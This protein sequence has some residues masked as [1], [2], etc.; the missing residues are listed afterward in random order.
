MRTL[1]TSLPMSAL[2]FATA[3]LLTALP[4]CAAS[5]P[6]S[7]EGAESPTAPATVSKTTGSSKVPGVTGV[8]T[9]KGTTSTST[10]TT[11]SMPTASKTSAGSTTSGWD[12]S[13]PKGSVPVTGG[14]LLVASDGA[15][16]IA[17]DPDR[18]LVSI[19]DLPTHSVVGQIQLPTGA[20]PGRVV[21]DGVG[22]IHVILRRGGGIADIDPVA[23]SLI[24]VRQVCALPRGIAYRASDDSLLVSCMSGALVTMTADPS[25]RAPLANVSV[26]TATAAITDL[27]DVLVTSGGVYLT[28]FRSA[29]VLQV[30]ADGSVLGPVVPMNTRVD[31]SAA[32]LA[33]NGLPGGT[34]QNFVPAVA[35]RAVAGPAGDI[36]VV[37][38]G[39]T[40][41]VINVSIADNGGTQVPVST[42]C[43]SSEYGGETCE[44]ISGAPICT[45]AILIGEI[46]S[47]S[48]TGVVSDGPALPNGALPVDIV[49]SIDGKSYIVALAGNPGGALSTEGKPLLNILKVPAVS[50]VSPAANAAT[51]DSD[52]CGL[53]F[54]SDGVSVP[55]QVTAV[56]VDVMGQTVAQT[57]EPASIQYVT[58]SGVISIPLSSVSVANAGFDLFHTNTGRGMTCAGCH[59][60][61]QDDGRTWQF[62]DGFNADGTPVAVLPR[63]TQTFRAGFLATAPFHWDGEFTDIPALMTDVFV[64]R[65]GASTAPTATQQTALETW[66]DG[67]PAKMHDTPSA[68]LAASIAIGA[69][70][71]QDPTVGCT[72]CHSGANF[73]NNTSTDIGF[74]YPLQVPTLIDVSFRGPFLHDGSAPTLEARFADPTAMSGK[75]GTTSQLSAA[76]IAN[77]VDYLGSL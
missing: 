23:H 57:R 17:A 63:R 53:A 25:T 40:D 71:F 74:G 9:P 35:W 24:G 60:E 64:H 3:A 21:E 13:A 16:A 61:G 69:T 44:T 77:L 48:A 26:H 32:A 73:T 22:Q 51:F 10:S 12:G 42:S 15:T 50:Q 14:T 20:E 19:V 55:G 8:T 37:H 59:A 76:Q 11:T 45:P 72:T 62:T 29:T 34:P 39:G 5:G 18:D 27:R 38:E 68:T 30:G 47:V 43:Q 54:N 75:H 31:P 67:I 28:T 49:P 46:S 33:A 7:L 2:T 58:A 6:D 56:A 70:L 36:V 1:N 65:M 41:R 52:L 66:M 4:G